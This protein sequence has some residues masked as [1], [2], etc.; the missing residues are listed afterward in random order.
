[1]ILLLQKEKWI[2]ELSCLKIS[3]I[4]GSMNKSY[5]PE[6]KKTI[7]QATTKNTKV[8]KDPHFNLF[9]KIQ[10]RIQKKQKH[11]LRN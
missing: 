11:K 6:K 7:L 10:Q 8:F 9:E 5:N 3:F 2:L 4:K 1:M